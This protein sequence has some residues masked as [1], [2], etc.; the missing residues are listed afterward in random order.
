MLRGQLPRS[1][2]N[3]SEALR[4]IR[5]RSIKITALRDENSPEVYIGIEDSLED[6]RNVFRNQY[7]PVGLRG[8][9]KGN[10]CVG[11]QHSQRE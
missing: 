5:P 6:A 8:A 10:G 9:E 11:L 2:C 3:H 1:R 7:C 4:G